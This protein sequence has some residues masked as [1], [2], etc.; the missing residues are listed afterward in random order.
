MRGVAV[1][2]DIPSNGN[3]YQDIFITL[4]STASAS[5]AEGEENKFIEAINFA[6]DSLSPEAL[7]PAVAPCCRP[8]LSGERRVAGRP[9]LA[10][11]TTS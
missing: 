9:R 11:T 8:L 4:K 3:I 7:P 6:A 10:A 2:A 5:T 1:C